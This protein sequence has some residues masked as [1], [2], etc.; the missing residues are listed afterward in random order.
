[1]TYFPD[2]EFSYAVF[3]G[4]NSKSS[5]MITGRIRNCEESLTHPLLLPGIFAELE[6][7]RQIDIVKLWLGKLLDTVN[8]LS[9]TGLD[10]E[11]ILPETGSSE[12][13]PHAMQPWI[14]VHHLKNGLE[15][16]RDQL[17]KMIDHSDELEEKFYRASEIPKEGEIVLG[18]VTTSDD[19]IR[20]TAEEHRKEVLKNSGSRIKERLQEI[21]CDYNEQIRECVLIMEGM[22]LATSLV[23]YVMLS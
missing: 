17:Q 1:M 11:T 20:S 7:R 4:C 16:F 6:R 8:S 10:Q 18:Y 23:R 13:S 14:N 12:E 19:V 3:Y 22:T 15:N 5:E 21:V 9:R 2:T